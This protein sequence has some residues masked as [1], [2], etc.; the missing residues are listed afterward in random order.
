MVEPR[1]VKSTNQGGH[2][3][4]GSV[5]DKDINDIFAIL[6]R[7]ASFSQKR[8]VMHPRDSVKVP[9]TSSDT[10]KMVIAKQNF[11]L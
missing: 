1:G 6:A 10:P 7:V 9:I 4:C 2:S 3:A 11:K 8:R 5:S